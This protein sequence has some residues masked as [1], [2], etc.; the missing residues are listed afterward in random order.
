MDEVKKLIEKLEEGDIEAAKT[1]GEMGDERAIETLSQIFI[2][3]MGKH[4]D[5]M[6]ATAAN[7]L[8]EICT[9]QSI[10]TLIFELLDSESAN[11]RYWAA[12]ALSNAKRMGKNAESLF[13]EVFLND[14]D[15]RVQQSALKTLHK[16]GTKKIDSM[17]ERKK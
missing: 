10:G 4:S 11:M 6:R 12:E 9:E 17:F 13:L 5:K 7:A 2:D 16:I 14:E 8:G 15:A 3:T 1:L